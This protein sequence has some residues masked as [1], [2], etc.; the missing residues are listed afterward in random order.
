MKVFKFIKIVPEDSK[1]V[2]YSR[3]VKSIFCEPWLRL[4]H[5]SVTQTPSYCSMTQANAV[6]QKGNFGY[7]Y[8]SLSASVKEQADDLIVAVTEVAVTDTA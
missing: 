2:S 8:I 4:S 1:P 7:S 3:L 6:F 5:S